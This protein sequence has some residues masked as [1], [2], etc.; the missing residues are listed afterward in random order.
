[1]HRLLSEPTRPEMAEQALPSL[2]VHA[3]RSVTRRHA[4]DVPLN[5]SEAEARILPI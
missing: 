4:I 1:M 2:N 3:R 5:H